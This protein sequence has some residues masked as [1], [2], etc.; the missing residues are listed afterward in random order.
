MTY[1]DE[2]LVPHSDREKMLVGA[3]LRKMRD[4][5]LEIEY[6]G[7]NDWNESKS[8]NLIHINANYRKPQWVY[9]CR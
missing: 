2:E 4:Q 5:V 1:M 6:P 3:L 9:T 7:T 8:S